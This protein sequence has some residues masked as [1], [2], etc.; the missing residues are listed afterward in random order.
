MPEVYGTPFMIY[1]MEVAASLAIQ[2]LLPP[3]WVSVGAEVNV[4]H[5]A[6]TPVGH[7]VTASA[8]VTAVADRLVH[9]AVEAHDGDEL[10]GSGTHVRAVVD[11]AKFERRIDNKRK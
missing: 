4:R 8:R 3:G 10:V 7:T 1:L 11:L 2:P 5:L 9:F 6:A